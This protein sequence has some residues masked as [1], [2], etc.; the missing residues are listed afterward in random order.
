V[1]RLRAAAATLEEDVWIAVRL[2]GTYEGE[3]PALYVV[4]GPASMDV[5]RVSAGV[6]VG[7]RSALQPS[8][9]VTDSRRWLTVTPSA[10]MV[11]Q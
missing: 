4:A 5:A 6:R 8:T 9:P 3:L 7:V 1:A 10:S 2:P 11:K